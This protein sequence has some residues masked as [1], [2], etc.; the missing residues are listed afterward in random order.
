[1]KVIYIAGA[2]RA[3]SEYGVK[4]NIEQ[5]EKVALDVWRSG[6]VALCPH[7]NTAFFGGAYG[8]K[9][10]IWLDGDLELLSRCDAVLT[11][12]NWKTS[13]GASIEIKVAKSKGIP[14]F[15]TLYDL[16]DWILGA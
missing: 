16:Q 14:V 1:M 4:Q 10:K 12:D 9:D 2:Y 15:H 8:L 11:V 13:G 7:K 3:D 5:A 6:C